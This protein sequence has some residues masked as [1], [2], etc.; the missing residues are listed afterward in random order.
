MRS[1]PVAENTAKQ[2][3]SAVPKFAV[4]PFHD[5]G[6]RLFGRVCEKNFTVPRTGTLLH[7]PVS[8]MSS[9]AGFA[10]DGT[11]TDPL[12]AIDFAESVFASTRLTSAVTIEGDEDR[13]S[14]NAA[15][16]A[17]ALAM[18]SCLGYCSLPPSMAT[19]IHFAFP[20]STA[21]L[22]PAPSSATWKSP[23]AFTFTP[24][25][26]TLHAGVASPFAA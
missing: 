11:A 5:T 13:V 14:A 3:C 22:S 18:S 21:S 10:F 20:A 1:V 24:S 2:L 17:H 23:S 7:L 25:I 16:D 4:D 19:P 15:F 8:L 9:G 26:W 12:T 6:P